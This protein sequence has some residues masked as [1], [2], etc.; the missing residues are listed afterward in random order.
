MLNRAGKP[1]SKKEGKNILDLW[2][3]G[4][5]RDIVRERNNEKRNYINK[6]IEKKR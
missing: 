5:L 3:D 1:M 6:R 4:K 2:V